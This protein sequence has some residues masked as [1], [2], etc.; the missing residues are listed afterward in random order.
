MRVSAPTW[1]NTPSRPPK[2]LQELRKSYMRCKWILRGILLGVFIGAVVI[3]GISA[4]FHNWS[5]LEGL[6]LGTWVGVLCVA[7]ARPVFRW[8]LNLGYACPKCQ[9]RATYTDHVCKLVHVTGGVM[10]GVPYYI[11][12]FDQYCHSCSHIGNNRI[13]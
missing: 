3:I 8:A 4:A 6:A 7:L 9:S 12:L 1:T 10:Q 2:E 13:L 5:A 11:E